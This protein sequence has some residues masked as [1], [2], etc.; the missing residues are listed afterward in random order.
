VGLA[1]QVA[2]A[3]ARLRELHEEQ[4]KKEAERTRASVALRAAM[5]GYEIMRTPRWG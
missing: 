3:R 4:R 1:E 5:P 2:G